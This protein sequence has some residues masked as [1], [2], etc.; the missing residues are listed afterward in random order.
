VVKIKIIDRGVVEHNKDKMDKQKH[1]LQGEYN[2]R[3]NKERSF[4][5]F[6]LKGGEEKK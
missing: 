6:F 5:S 3:G 4:L 2:L 1:H